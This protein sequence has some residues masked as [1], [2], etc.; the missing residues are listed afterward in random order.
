LGS[1]DV[2]CK[3]KD[4][5]G[6]ESAAKTFKVTVQDTTAPALSLP[7]DITKEAT[8]AAGAVATY[9]AAA[10][11]LVDGPVAIGCSPAS[12]TT[13]ALGTTTVNCSAK[14][15]HN[16]QGSGSFKITVKD[17]TTPTLTVPADI[18]KTAT[19]A[20]GAAVNYVVSA[21][22]IVDP[23][24]VISCKVGTAIAPV[25]G[26]TFLG[27]TTITCTA[28]DNAN[29][30]SD[31]KSFKIIVNF[32][33]T[34]FLNP[35]DNNKALNGMKAGSTA[36]MKWQIPNSSGGYISDL[37]IVK[38]ETSGVVACVGGVLDPLEEYA[39]GGTS[40][41]YDSTSN[42]FIYN[43]QSPKKAGT[44]YQ[45]NIGLAD[46]TVHSAIFQLN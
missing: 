1:T 14:D 11:D 32:G 10:S 8:S 27:I 6:N 24:P 13:F 30:Q 3:A 31:P 26:S 39:T 19:S 2:S 9:S 29:N 36:P 15:S 37:S 28:K 16:N 46:G 40:L 18:T 45:V 33:F 22:D 41:R 35:V 17:T 25:S 23:S 20:A 42:Q 21:S 4:N 44:C 38:S 7:S 43:W 34:G 5:A 12:G